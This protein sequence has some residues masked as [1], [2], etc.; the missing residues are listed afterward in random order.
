MA[1]ESVEPLNSTGIVSGVSISVQSPGC[2]APLF[3]GAP[4]SDPSSIVGIHAFTQATSVHGLFKALESTRG[5]VATAWI[6]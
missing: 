5:S 6:P 4:Q 3:P 2:S 1:R